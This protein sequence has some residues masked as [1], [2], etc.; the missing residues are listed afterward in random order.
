M[1]SRRREAE[2]GN[3]DDTCANEARGT[4]GPLTILSTLCM[5]DIFHNKMFK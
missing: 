2:G 1:G 5:S 3:K 4:Q